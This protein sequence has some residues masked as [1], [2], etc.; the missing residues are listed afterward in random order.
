MN[1]FTRHGR[2]KS[3][4]ATPVYSKY[5]YARYLYVEL[6]RDISFTPRFTT[7]FPTRNGHI[8]LE[9]QRKEQT[10]EKLCS[11]HDD[12]AVT[13]KSLHFC[14]RAT[15]IL[16]TQ[17]VEPAR[18]PQEGIPALC[19]LPIGF[20]PPPLTATAPPRFLYQHRPTEYAE[21]ADPHISKGRPAAKIS[22]GR[23]QTNGL[24]G[25]L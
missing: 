17:D 18:C 10:H 4:S 25:R 24:I 1:N 2:A 7:Y 21:Y 15:K 3:S 22:K 12:E 14:I 8:Q 11:I 5:Q 13:K 20:D 6:V 9:R 16:A 19:V 23:K